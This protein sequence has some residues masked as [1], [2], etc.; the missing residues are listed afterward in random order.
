VRTADAQAAAQVLFVTVGEPEVRF[1]VVLLDRTVWG[2]QELAAGTPIS[3][4]FEVEQQQ[5]C[6]VEAMAGAWAAALAPIELIFTARDGRQLVIM[7]AGQKQLVL[8]MSP[9]DDGG[10]DG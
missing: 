7:A 9:F 10:T 1:D 4:S 8:S 6:A 5:R 3:I 2:Q